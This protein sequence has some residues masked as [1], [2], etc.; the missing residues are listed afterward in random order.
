VSLPA[1]TAADLLILVTHTGKP[2]LLLLVAL[3]HAFTHDTGH[4][5]VMQIKL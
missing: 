3:R 4:T 2:D 5:Q 1:C